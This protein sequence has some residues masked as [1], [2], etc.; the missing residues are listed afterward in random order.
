MRIRMEQFD[1]P[2][3]ETASGIERNSNVC[4]RRSFLVMERPLITEAGMR[5]ANTD[6]ATVVVQCAIDAEIAGG[7]FHGK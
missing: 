2:K 6:R 7:L 3:E 5:I 4:V 1:K